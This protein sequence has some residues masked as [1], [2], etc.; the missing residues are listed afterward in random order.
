[1]STNQ[2][3][4]TL[5]EVMG[6]LDE[7]AAAAKVGDGTRYRAALT[8]AERPMGPTPPRRGRARLAGQR[9]PPLRP[10]RAG[11]RRLPVLPQL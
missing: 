5:A 3:P 9:P 8:V 2:T 6:T 4:P 1:M 11:P 10:V 7:L